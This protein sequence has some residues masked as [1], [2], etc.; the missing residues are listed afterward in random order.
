MA[1]PIKATP[2]LKN[3]SSDRFNRILTSNQNLKIQSDKKDAI[4][5]LVHKVL[6][7]SKISK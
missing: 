3:A 4:F 1:T 5:S 2:V 7:K 6:S